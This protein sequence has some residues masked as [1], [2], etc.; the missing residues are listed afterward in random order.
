[1]PTHHLTLRDMGATPPP[2]GPSFVCSATTACLIASNPS[3]SAAGIRTN[4]PRATTMNP[5]KASRTAAVRLMFSMTHM[6]HLRPSFPTI[7]IPKSPR[8]HHTEPIP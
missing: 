2:N 8:T 3:C 1:M 7:L 5:V 6:V 4:P